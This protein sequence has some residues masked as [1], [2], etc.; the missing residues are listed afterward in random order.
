[1]FN[2]EGIVK[3]AYFQ[4]K[5]EY[6]FKANIFLLNTKKKNF[7]LAFNLQND[8]HDFYENLPCLP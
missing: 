3:W 5:V 7:D 1:M 2:P 8:F 4:K 6:P